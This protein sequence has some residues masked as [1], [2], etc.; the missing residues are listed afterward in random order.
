MVLCNLINHL[1]FTILSHIMQAAVPA[2]LNPSTFLSRPS[3]FLE[4]LRDHS[5]TI[6]GLI[7]WRGSGLHCASSSDTSRVGGQ[8][9]E[10]VRKQ[11]HHILERSVSEISLKGSQDKA[12]SPTSIA[13][14][15]QTHGPLIDRPPA[16]SMAKQ[17]VT[18]DGS[19]EHSE[20]WRVM[21][22]DSTE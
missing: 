2:C 16:C 10:N 6:A 17:A 3:P 19:E 4:P 18:I 8:A 12:G 7:Y 20:H 21:S 11:S 22:M 13:R 5:R 9:F 14:R 15:F 1:R